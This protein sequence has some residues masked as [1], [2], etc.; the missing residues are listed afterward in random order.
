MDPLTSAAIRRAQDALKLAMQ[1]APNRPEFSIARTLLGLADGRLDGYEREVLQELGGTEFDARRPIVPLALLGRDLTAAGDGALVGVDNLRPESLL[2]SYSVVARAGVTIVDGLR[3]DATVP[4]A[5]ARPAITWL[6]AENSA[7][8]EVQPT[9]GS[10]AL[11]PKHAAALTRASGQ[12]LRQSPYA[13]GFVRRQLAE[14]AGIAADIAVLNGTGANGQPLGILGTSGIGS[15]SGTSLGL[16]GVAAMKAAVADAGAQDQNISFIGSTDV[17]ETLE[18]RERASGSGFVWD[19]GRVASLPA[20]ATTTMPAATLLAGDFSRVT[21]GIWGLEVL[22]DE[23]TYF[24]YGAVQYRVSLLCDVGVTQ[25]AA[26]CAA[27]SI[28]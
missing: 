4:V 22:A 11:A 7:L 3:G 10:V 25:P 26:F 24:A 21:L 13:E 15:V 16:A 28:T 17:R 20:Y 27:S 23:S 2:R 8:S 9:V 19:A 14:A 18:T 12:M 6:S 5:T 1:P